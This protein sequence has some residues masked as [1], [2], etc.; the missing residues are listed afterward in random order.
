MSEP[1]PI[2]ID[3]ARFFDFIADPALAVLFV[4]I[5]PAHRFNRA[6]RQHLASQHPDEITFGSISFRDLVLNGGPALSFLQQGLEACGGPS[7]F[8]VLPG[9]WLVRRGEVLAWDAGL[10]TTADA[11]TLAQGALLGAIWSGLTRNLSFVAQALR[12]AADEVAAR[13]MAAAFHTAAVAPESSRPRRP[14][15]A[16]RSTI[17]ELARA[18]QTLGVSPTATDQDVQQAWRRRRVE[19]HP[20]AAVRDPAEFERRSRISVELNRARD[21]IFAHRGGTAGRR[22]A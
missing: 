7:S 11:G 12:L 1:E 10:P 16:S 4:S 17:D 6:L 14:P 22:T 8:G 13:R 3:A 18:Y 2:P 9:Y 19:L 5:H 20:D 15:P 21:I